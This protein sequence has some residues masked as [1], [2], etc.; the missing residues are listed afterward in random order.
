MMVSS[1]YV[2]QVCIMLQVWEPTAFK[3]FFVEQIKGMLMHVDV[4]VSSVSSIIRIVCF[5][6]TGI[7]AYIWE[8]FAECIRLYIS[9]LNFRS[10]DCKCLSTASEDY[11][12][13]APKQSVERVVKGKACYNKHNGAIIAPEYPK[14]PC[15]SLSF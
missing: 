15:L 4:C 8:V 12:L 7:A 5:V 2:I 1:W 13:I 10:N 9:L 3:N 11:L 14:L 6:T